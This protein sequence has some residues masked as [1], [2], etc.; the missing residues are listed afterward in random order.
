[1]WPLL[2][3]KGVTFCFTWARGGKSVGL[4]V[5]QRLR[6]WHLLL[7]RVNG[8]RSSVLM[9]STYSTLERLVFYCALKQKTK[10][11]WHVQVISG[12]CWGIYDLRTLTCQLIGTCPCYCPFRPG[13]LSCRTVWQVG[14]R[15]LIG[16]ETRGSPEGPYE[17]SNSW[18]GSKQNQ[19]HA[20]LT[21]ETPRPA[22]RREAAGAKWVS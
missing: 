3:P 21:P 6:E 1:M 2:A 8:A 15:A 18:L 7:L 19:G 4:C 9:R 5:I 13:L 20:T 12:N 17:E 11:L 16:S 14:P 10:V 22:G